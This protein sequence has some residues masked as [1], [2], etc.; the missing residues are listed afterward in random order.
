M[1]YPK[2]PKKRQINSENEDRALKIFIQ[3]NRFSGK[4][5]NN[6][7]KKEKEDEHEMSISCKR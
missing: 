5:I 2:Y 4:L 1:K 3:K 6:K 7:R